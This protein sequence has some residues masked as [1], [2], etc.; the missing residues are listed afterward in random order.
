LTS[1]GP[2]P[3]DAETLGRLEELEAMGARGLVSRVLTAYL[4]EAPVL[5][6]RIEQAVESGDPKAMLQAAHALRS[7]STNVGALALAERCGAA[8][9]TGRSGELGG[10]ASPAPSLRAEFEAVRR[11]LAARLAALPSSD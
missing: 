10:A 4:Q 11:A 5:M 9:A 3:I 8:E 2:E 1:V 7:S 6:E